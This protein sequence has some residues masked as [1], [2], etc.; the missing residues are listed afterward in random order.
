MGNDKL[1][2]K[3]RSIQLLNYINDISAGRLITDPFFQRNLVWR[4]VHK[5]DFIQT[6]LLGYPF[7]QIF[8]TKGKI[9]LTKQMSIASIVDG[10]QRTNA[11]LDFIQNKFSVNEKK[12]SELSDS[13][14]ERFYKYEIAIIELDLDHDDKKVQ[15]IFQRINRT[16]NSLTNIEKKASEYSFSEYMMIAEFMSSHLAIVGLDS[17]EEILDNGSDVSEI[18]QNPYIKD[19]FK[20]WIKSNPVKNYEKLITS[21]NLFTSNEIAKKVNLMY[22]LNLMTT[23]LVG[24]I[25]NRNDKVWELAEEYAEDFPDKDLIVNVF[26]KV[27]SIILAL[28]LK[29]NSFWYRKANF[30]TLFTVLA[31]NIKNFSSTDKII[32]LEIIAQL[33]DKLDNFEPTEAYRNAAKEGVNNAKE[34]ELR[35][36]E[37]SE[38]LEIH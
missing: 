11:I 18:K 32:Q 29:K 12:F 35:H 34:R 2:Y 22:T 23:Y 4:E 8:I 21:E 31:L 25:Y 38:F 37:L 28:K 30:F 14:K 33:K 6:I 20:N 24:Y 36:N 19:L 1:D 17:D 10:Q 7:P 5:K 26:E 13:E 15:E 3:I 16:S 9:D 27:A